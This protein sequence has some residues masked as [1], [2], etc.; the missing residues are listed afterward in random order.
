MRQHSTY[1][2]GGA[3]RQKRSTPDGGC[4]EWYAERN[5][6]VL[7]AYRKT[8]SMLDDAFTREVTRMDWSAVAVDVDREL[9]SRKNVWSGRSIASALLNV[10]K[11]EYDGVGSGPRRPNIASEY[12]AINRVA[13]QEATKRKILLQLLS[14]TKLHNSSFDLLESHFSTET[15]ESMDLGNICS[16]IEEKVQ[17]GDFSTVVAEEEQVWL[18][19]LRECLQG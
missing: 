5:A 11:A 17:Q 15:F 13:M 19:Q 10:L 12:V 14:K 4:I 16:N 18:C 2:P 7:L 9:K 8:T 3:G 6:V 1:K